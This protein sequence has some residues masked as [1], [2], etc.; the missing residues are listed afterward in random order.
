[1][2]TYQFNVTSL[3]REIPETQIGLQGL[4]EIDPENE[5]IEKWKNWLKN[6]QFDHEY[7]DDG[8]IWLTDVLALMAVNS[9]NFGIGSV[10]I[11]GGGDVVVQGH[12][13]IFNPYFR[14]D[15]HGEMVVMDE[16]EETHRDVTKLEGYTVHVP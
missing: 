11:D 4:L 14:S 16:F 10:L 8:Y 12:N 5:S 7:P 9:G 6:Y 15:R 13:E 3:Q 2:A 1:M